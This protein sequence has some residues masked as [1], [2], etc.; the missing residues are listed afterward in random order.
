MS[1][2][3]SFEYRVCFREPTNVIGIR[4]EK[5]IRAQDAIPRIVAEGGTEVSITEPAPWRIPGTV[6]F[7]TPVSSPIELP[8]GP[9]RHSK[10]YRASSEFHIDTLLANLSLNLG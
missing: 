5:L 4:S 8:S 3:P 10:N 7:R 1:P 6:I 9:V 2:R